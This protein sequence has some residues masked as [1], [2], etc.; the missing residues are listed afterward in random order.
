MGEGNNDELYLVYLYCIILYSGLQWALVNFSICTF[1]MAKNDI[2]I[3]YK[4][5]EI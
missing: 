2:E 1:L 5:Q 3:L 4:H